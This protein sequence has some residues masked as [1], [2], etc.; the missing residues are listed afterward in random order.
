MLLYNLRGARALFDFAQFCLVMFTVT[1]LTLSPK[2][3]RVNV[4]PPRYSH[5]VIGLSINATN[6]DLVASHLPCLIGGGARG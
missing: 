2:L 3:L 1:A 5:F 6:Q 4:A